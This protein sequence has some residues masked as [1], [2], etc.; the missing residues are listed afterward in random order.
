M[1]VRHS[2][3]NGAQLRLVAIMCQLE[4]SLSMP[5]WSTV[6]CPAVCMKLQRLRH[7]RS[8]PCAS[9]YIV[10]VVVDFAYQRPCRSQVRS[11][12]G[13][14]DVLIVMY[15]QR[16]CVLRRPLHRHAT[17]QHCPSCMSHDAARRCRHDPVT[18]L[19]RMSPLL[20]RLS[21]QPQAVPEKDTSAWATPAARTKEVVVRRMRFMFFPRVAIQNKNTKPRNTLVKHYGFSDVRTA[22]GSSDPPV[23][24]HRNANMMHRCHTASVVFSQ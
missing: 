23:T 22:L 9:S 11:H 14:S 2:N 24:R 10:I 16:L 5:A 1:S 13:F 15:A 12:C 6:S 8:L 20:H 21:V 4:T 18:L 3:R 7:R 19:R 17:P